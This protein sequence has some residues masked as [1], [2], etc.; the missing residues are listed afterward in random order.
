MSSQP[1]RTLWKAS[2]LA[3]LFS[4]LGFTIALAASG[5]LDTTFSGD[6]KQTTDFA[7]GLSEQIIGMRLQP[8]GKIVAVGERWD[9]AHYTTS[10]SHNFALA[11]YKTDG[12]L[13]PTFS[14]DGKQLTDFGAMDGADDAAIQ[15]DGKIVVSGDRCNAAAACDLA[16]AR[17]N[18]NGTLD[19]TFSGDGKQLVP[20]GG[21][22]NGT[23]GGL[24]IQADGKIVIGGWMTNA[25]GDQDFAVYRL[26]ANG[27][28]DAT[29]S[30][31]GKV[32]F[33]FGAGRQD[34][35]YDLLLQSGEILI[36]GRTCDATYANCDFALARLTST[37]ALDATFSGDGKQ[38]TNFGGSEWIDGLALQSDGKLVTAGVKESGASAYFAL[39][40]YK[41]D[42]SLDPT[43]S[44]D[45]RQVVA[46]GGLARAYRVVVEPGGKLVVGGMG[47]R[48]ATNDFALARLNS[49]G[50]LDTTFS[51]DGKVSVSFGDD[52]RALGL[53]RQGDGK[54]ALG[55]FTENG[56]TSDFALARILP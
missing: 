33:G 10:S 17:Y 28:M 6:G 36:G 15:A 12:S 45:G 13:D 47:H 29:F 25:S 50:S 49:N 2:L 14:G 20:F 41:T 23:W 18:S 24:A 38:T 27:T 32:N 44:G 31:D 3:M 22:S 5:D 46:F 34:T 48:G 39:A 4:L 26:N 56:S 43:F 55:G 19:P 53:V 51:G 21:G 54:Y 37:G 1:N 40:R 8:D 11:R 7:G 42:G 9:Q 35:A 30:G 16:M 52:D